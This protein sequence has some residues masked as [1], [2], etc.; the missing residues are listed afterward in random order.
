MLLPSLA[1][2]SASFQFPCLL[3]NSKWIERN[4]L[5]TYHKLKEQ[6]LHFF[7]FLTY[8]PSVMVCQKLVRFI[9]KTLL[10]SFILI[11][12]L[13]WVEMFPKNDAEIINKNC[14]ICESS[15]NMAMSLYS[16]WKY[17]NPMQNNEYETK[18]STGYI[19]ILF[20]L[21]LWNNFSWSA[22]NERINQFTA[23]VQMR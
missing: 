10:H 11:L 2:I 17:M 16:I 7:F 15:Q 3:T 21:N 18:R 22:L 14:F 6:T 9:F 19:P 4:E 23:Y 13:V 8:K 5:R 1:L 12:K 20:F